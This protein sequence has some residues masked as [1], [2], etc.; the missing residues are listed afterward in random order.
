M[1]H[2]AS[3]SAGPLLL[4][5]A[6]AM[7]ALGWLLSSTSTPEEKISMAIEALR[8]YGFPEEKPLVH[9]GTSLITG[10]R[11]AILDPKGLMS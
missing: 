4:E 11:V 1:K 8:K 5:P 3:A 2:A 7:L 9:V 10:N 6:P